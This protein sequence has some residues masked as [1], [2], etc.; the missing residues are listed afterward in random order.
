MRRI[1]IY[2]LLAL[3]LHLRKKPADDGSVAHAEAARLSR[4]TEV[5]KILLPTKNDAGML[6]AKWLRQGLQRR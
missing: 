3:L 6:R 5:A 4:L 1:G 2:A